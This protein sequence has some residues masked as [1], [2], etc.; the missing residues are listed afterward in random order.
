MATAEM[1][2]QPERIYGRRELVKRCPQVIRILQAERPEEIFPLLVEGI[3][4]L[5]YPRALVADVNL[6][7]GEITPAAVLKWPAP[8]VK[9]FTAALWTTEH[10]LAGVLHANRPAVLTKTN[11]HNRPIYLHPIFYSNHNP[12]REAEGVC[13]MDCLASQNFRREKRVR[14]EEQMCSVCGIRAYAAVVVV[15]LPRDNAE[16]GMAD[17]G[18]LVEVANHSLYRLFKAEYYYKRARDL[19]STVAQLG[20]VRQDRDRL[21]LILENVGDALVG[22]DS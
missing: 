7:A 12:C 11:L 6:D 21:N 10:P 22:C 16:E 1:P 3:L 8:Q 18:E 4:A 14:R 5:G 13:G 2:F 17:L 19:E 20:T 15:E 9:K